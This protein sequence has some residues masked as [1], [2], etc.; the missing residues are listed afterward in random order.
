[1]NT[2]DGQSGIL[3][4]DPSTPVRNNLDDHKYD[5]IADLVEEAWTKV[6]RRKKIRRKRND[7]PFLEY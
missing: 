5:Q 7:R 4:E 6:V 2:I 1:V 3:E